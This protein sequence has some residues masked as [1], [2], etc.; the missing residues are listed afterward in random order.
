MS[1][2]FLFHAVIIDIHI[3][4]DISKCPNF[5]YNLFPPA[6]CSGQTVQFHLAWR[7]VEY[8]CRHG[9]YLM[10]LLLIFMLLLI[11]RNV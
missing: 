9:F 4:I 1:T 8:S 2:W 3:V 10:L 7:H 6:T 5:F 11:L